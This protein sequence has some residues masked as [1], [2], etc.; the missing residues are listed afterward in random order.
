MTLNKSKIVVGAVV[1]AGIA[2]ASTYQQDDQ[3]D[4]E[5]VGICAGVGTAVG[6][7]SSYSAYKIT[8][9]IKS[10]FPKANPSS[11]IK[12]FDTYDAFK[13]EFGKASDYVPD[14]E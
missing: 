14:G 2:A 7:I 11:N 13:K 5:T 1:E 8:S 9:A 4:W 6:A 3:V 10:L 12:S